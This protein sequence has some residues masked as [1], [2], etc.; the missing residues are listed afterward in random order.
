MPAD[1]VPGTVAV[2]ITTAAGTSNSFNITVTGQPTITSLSP[3]TGPAGTTITITGTN[4]GS[5][6][7]PSPN[8][9]VLLLS[10]GPQLTPISWSDTQIVAQIPAGSTP[11]YVN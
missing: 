9:S 1:T 6:P 8:T 5:A 2:Q 3:T 7:L 4:F 10:P 11:G